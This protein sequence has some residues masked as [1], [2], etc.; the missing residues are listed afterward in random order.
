MTP[1]MRLPLTATHDSYS[2]SF[3]RGPPAASDVHHA[4][5]PAAA[6]AIAASDAKADAGAGSATNA[7]ASAAAGGAGDPSATAAIDRP[8][9]AVVAVPGDE[10]SSPPTSAPAPEEADEVAVADRG[11]TGNAAAQPT[12]SA[13][14]CRGAE[15]GCMPEPRSSA[16]AAAHQ[17]TPA[18]TSS[19]TGAFHGTASP[20]QNAEAKGMHEPCQMKANTAS[21]TGIPL[22]VTP[23]TS[24]KTS[25]ESSSIG[26]GW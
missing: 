13:E 4:P 23:C 5:A 12:A 3:S 1:G 24:S 7:A 21:T 2:I 8:T 26:F 11:P 10:Q 19:G 14:H 20:S 6:A 18:E 17:A 25:V 9:T 15:H 16:M 22:Q